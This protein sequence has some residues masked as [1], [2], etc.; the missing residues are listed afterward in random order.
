MIN[1]LKKIDI[2][3]VIIIITTSV[4]ILVITMRS[5]TYS[6]GYE[7]ASLKKNE[8]QLIQ[9]QI[10]LEL[11]LIQTQKMIREK[12]LSEQDK[13]GNMKYHLPDID[14]VIREE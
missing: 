2:M 4:G 7:I 8:K 9:K 1:F 13:K 10:E 5:K 12:L 6:V 3:V 11:N 14:S